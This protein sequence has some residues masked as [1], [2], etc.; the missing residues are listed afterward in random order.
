[1]G[2]LVSSREPLSAYIFFGPVYY[3]KLKHMVL[4]KMHARAKVSGFPTSFVVILRKVK[5]DVP[6]YRKFSPN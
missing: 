5:T 6:Y 3:Q 1:M 2:L 4:D